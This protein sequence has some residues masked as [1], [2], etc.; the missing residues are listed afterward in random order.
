MF[1]KNDPSQVIPKIC[2]KM[3]PRAPTPT[4]KKGPSSILT[5]F[6]TATIFWA[7]CAIV[8]VKC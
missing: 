8:V 6:N 3:E 7:K 1:G 2:V 5:D 4:Q